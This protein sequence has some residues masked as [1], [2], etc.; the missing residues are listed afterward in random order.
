ML[1]FIQNYKPFATKLEN[2]NESINELI[3][4]Y[5]TYHLILISDFVPL[6]NTDLR[7]V[8]GYNLIIFVTISALYFLFSIIKKLVTSLIMYFVNKHRARKRLAREIEY[9]LGVI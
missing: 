3:I 2:T 8:V 9:M 7:V 5:V 6:S 4:M 1:I